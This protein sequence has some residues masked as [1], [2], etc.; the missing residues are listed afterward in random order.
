MKRKLG[1]IA[2]CIAGAD[3]VDT[4]D[5]MK[6]IGFDSFFTDT[7]SV[8]TTQRMKQKADALGLTYEFIHAPFSG[9][10][11]MWIEGDAYLTVY[12][13][14]IDAI[15]AAAACS[16]PAVILHVSSGWDTPRSTIW[17]LPDLMQS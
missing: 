12:N 13:G 10:N 1:I 15:D 4:L 7:Y 11:N 6:E 3:P 17:A 14:M 5:L 8:E 16:V 2:E 9:I